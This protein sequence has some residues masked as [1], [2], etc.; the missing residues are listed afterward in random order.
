MPT[1]ILLLIYFWTKSVEGIEGQLSYYWVEYD[2]LYTAYSFKDA[3]NHHTVDT[4]CNK[5][6]GA[7]L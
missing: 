6:S 3:S 7:P 2:V 4:T 1:R 5:T